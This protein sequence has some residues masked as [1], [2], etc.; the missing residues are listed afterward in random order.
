MQFRVS[1]KFRHSHHRRAT[2]KP[3]KNTAP[4]KFQLL[5]SVRTN[6]AQ[7][8]RQI[9]QFGGQKQ[10]REIERQELIAAAWAAL[11]STPHTPFRCHDLRRDWL[12]WIA[13]PRYYNIPHKG[14]HRRTTTVGVGG[15]RQACLAPASIQHL[16]GRRTAQIHDLYIACMRRAPPIHA[17]TRR[18]SERERETKSHLAPGACAI[19]FRSRDFAVRP[20]A[21]FLINFALYTV[22]R[23]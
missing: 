2:K 13:R 6:L 15:G 3:K 12:F 18:L 23:L 21:T 11:K 22:K 9:W 8:S 4:C 7:F 1:N 19:I 10:R 5:R 17:R 16:K 14:I 20:P